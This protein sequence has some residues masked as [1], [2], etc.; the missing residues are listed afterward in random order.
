[1]ANKLGKAHGDKDEVEVKVADCQE[2]LAVKKTE[3]ERMV[4]VRI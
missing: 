4:E 3:M 1:L 2:K